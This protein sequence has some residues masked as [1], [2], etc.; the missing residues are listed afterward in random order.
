MIR[1]KHEE[2][3]MIQIK[4]IQNEKCNNKE[5]R[6]ELEGSSKLKGFFPN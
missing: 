2:K 1:N 5:M 4:I 3:Y 6:K